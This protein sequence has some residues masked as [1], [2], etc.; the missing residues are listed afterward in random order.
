[1]GY[2][3]RFLFT[4]EDEPLT[5]DLVEGGLKELDPGYA[6]RRAE[7]AKGEQADLYHGDALHGE[8]EINRA[9]SE[10]FDEEREELME[11]VAAVEDP[12]QQEV[13]GFL[14]RVQGAVVIRVL[15]QGREVEPTLE[16]LD[17]LW[18]WLFERAEGLLQADGEGYY[19]AEGDLVLEVE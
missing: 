14:E 13:L 8:L 17:P 9:G 16:Q 15:W 2:Y 1:M 18:G 4:S 3:M 6:L 19:D 7:G 12:A 11:T 10:L 5:L